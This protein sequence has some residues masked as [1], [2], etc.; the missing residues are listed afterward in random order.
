[1][2][3]VEDVSTHLEQVGD[4]FGVSILLWCLVY[5]LEQIII[6]PI[7]LLLEG[8]I[9]IYLIRLQLQQPA[10]RLRLHKELLPLIRLERIHPISKHLLIVNI[11]IVFAEEKLRGLDSL[12]G[13]ERVHL[14]TKLV[15]LKYLLLDHVVLLLNVL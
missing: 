7:G 11:L 3:C 10:H 8:I 9:L 6:P 15:I 12:F 13:I 1:M 2:H 4:D 14:D 5:S